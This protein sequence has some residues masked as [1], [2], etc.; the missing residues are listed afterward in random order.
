VE[1]MRSLHFGF[2]SDRRT[3]AHRWCH[4]SSSSSSPSPLAL[5]RLLYNKVRKSSR[6]PHAPFLPLANGR[7][8]SSQLKHRP[9]ILLSSLTLPI[10]LLIP[11]SPLHRC[12]PLM[13]QVRVGTS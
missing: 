12:T 1:H 11:L 13:N 3:I 9:K 10:T 5:T 8:S 7:Y 2:F 4:L 6:S